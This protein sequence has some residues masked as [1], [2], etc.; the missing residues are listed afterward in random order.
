MGLLVL[1]ELWS[2]AKH[3]HCGDVVVSLIALFWRFLVVSGGFWRFLYMLLFMY[4]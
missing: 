2:E 4:T 3:K 1:A